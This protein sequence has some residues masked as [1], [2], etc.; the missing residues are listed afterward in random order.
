MLVATAAPRAVQ[1]HHCFTMGLL[2]L[3]SVGDGCVR[4]RPRDAGGGALAPGMTGASGTGGTG[5]AG[6]PLCASAGADPAS[7]PARTSVGAVGMD[8]N[9][10]LS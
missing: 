10:S 4:S 9:R 5:V 8:L 2:L 6:G 1:N 3:F 7:N